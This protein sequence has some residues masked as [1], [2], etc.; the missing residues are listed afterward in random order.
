M[1][2]FSWQFVLQQRAIIV[3]AVI[4]INITHNL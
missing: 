3:A 4:F 2:G 1:R